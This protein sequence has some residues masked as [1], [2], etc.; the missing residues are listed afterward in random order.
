[1]TITAQ[2]ATPPTITIPVTLTMAADT[3]PAL[4]V[5]PS[6]FQL[7]YVQGSPL[8]HQ[9]L[10]VSDLGAGSGSFNFQAQTTSCGNWLAPANG[11]A[12]VTSGVPLVLD[13]TVDPSGLPAGTCSGQIVVALDAGQSQTVPITMVISGQSQSLLLS[14]TGLDLQ[15]AAGSPP[16]TQ[17]FGIV[18]SGT[19][20]M[21]WN[22]PSSGTGWLKIHPSRAV[23]RSEERLPLRW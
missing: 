12:S 19:G 14:Q 9:Q 1:M 15:L 23:S 22:I 20:S 5:S 7:S 2:N 4:G 21:N 17:T 3:A 11:S 18:N 13:F 6:R 16:T 8:D 10:V